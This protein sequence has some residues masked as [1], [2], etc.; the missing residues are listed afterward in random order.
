MTYNDYVPINNEQDSSAASSNTLSLD[1]GIK[2]IE[3]TVIQVPSPANKHA[4]V[5]HTKVVTKD[6]RTVADFGTSEQ[7][8]SSSVEEAL[9]KAKEKALDAVLRSISSLAQ[10][11]SYHAKSGNDSG[12]SDAPVL[13]S[14][15]AQRGSTASKVAGAKNGGGTK[16]ASQKQ[17]DY[18]NSLCKKN[19]KNVE[20]IARS[21][22]GKTA[23]ELQ[24]R[25]VDRL[26]KSLQPAY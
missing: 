12:W 5:C 23:G 6:G 10:A 16:P 14:N 11:D 13:P 8:E 21:E 20:Q 24:G 26:I 2:D 1:F 3:T 17:L 9:N 19:G 15:V 7:A 4:A 22:F 18:L 25:E